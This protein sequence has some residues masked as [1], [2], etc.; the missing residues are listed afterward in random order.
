MLENLFLR[1]GHPLPSKRQHAPFRLAQIKYGAKQQFANLPDASLKQVQ[2]I[3]GSL[4]YY[5]NAVDNKLLVTLSKIGSTQAAA[6]EIT[7]SDFSLIPDYLA[8]YPYN[9]IL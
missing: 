8:T 1:W 9:G 6:T 7:N 5:I 4:L 2:A 3:F